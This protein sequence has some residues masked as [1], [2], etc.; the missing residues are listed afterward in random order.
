VS[1]LVISDLHLGSRLRH[2]VLAC[3]EPLRRLLG[4]LEGVDRLVLLGDVV[5]LLEERPVRAMAA[6]EPILR[7]IGGTLGT[8]REVVFVP[9]NHDRALIAG[10]IRQVGAGLAGD[11]RV[12]VDATPGLARLTSWLAPA[13]VRVHY[14]GVWLAPGVWATHGHYLD[15]HLLPEAA[16]G[17]TRG[18]LGRVP[19]LGARPI[20]YELAGGPSFTR[21]EALVIRALPRPLAALA[22]DVAELLRASTMP[23]A[24][25]RLLRPGMARLTARVLG[26]QMRRA[27][28]PAL[29]HV[30]RRLGVDAR[31]VLFGHVHRLG[32]LPGDLE[33]RWQGPQGRP[34]L[35]NTGSWV[36]EPLLVH[37]AAAPHPYWPGGAVSLEEGG[38]PRALGLLD[39]VPAG[40]MHRGR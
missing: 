38:T 12:P 17:V 34:R 20:D 2:D 33:A 13:R 36:Y 39:A 21:L 16:Y 9:G 11:S 32:P 19:Q 14:P 22:E 4:A 8:G 35:L 18:F 40:E 6:A 7:S 30:V 23:L 24:P 26:A 5:E 31:W 10:W 37:N 28:L 29:A 3:P 15:R 27:S 1:T 25:H